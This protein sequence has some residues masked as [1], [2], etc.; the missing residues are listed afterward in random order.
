MG[1]HFLIWLMIMFFTPLAL[2]A[3]LSPKT[4]SGYIRQDY[5]GA[6][7]ILGGKEQI[8][9]ELIALYKKNLTA[10]AAFANEFRDRHDDSDKF[11]NSGDHIGEAIADIPGDW[12]ASV[13]LQAYSTAL[14]VVILTKWGIW[15]V[16]PMV[17]GL[18][19]GVLERRLKLDT[20]S[21]PIPPIYNTSA[22]MLLALSCM[23]LLWLICPIPIPLSII[24]TI[25]VLI[26]IFISLAIANYPNY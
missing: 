21:P 14:R 7:T 22:H 11:R 6:I 5:N 23:L 2:P 10:I 26:S 1:K 17:M 18:V 24:P 20:F 15:L 19:V 9:L 25:A 3:L 16:L 8:N 13:K 12:A 4:L